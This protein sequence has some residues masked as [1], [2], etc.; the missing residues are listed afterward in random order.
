M[1]Q[2]IQTVYLFFAAII[3]ALVGFFPW[4][5]SYVSTEGAGQFYTATALGVEANGVA[6]SGISSVWCWL[7]TLAALAGVVFS[8]W[9]LVGFKNRVGQ[10]RHCIYAIL[11]LVLFYVL[12]GVELWSIS[13]VTGSFP[14]PDLVGQ[15]PLIAIILIFLAGRAIKRDEDLVRSTERIR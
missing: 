2:R 6:D 9:A 12:F 1:I 5:H 15:C 4:A 3:I 8:L 13:K 7:A 11:S 10:M 14:S